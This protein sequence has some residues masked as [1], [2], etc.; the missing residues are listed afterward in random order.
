MKKVHPIEMLV[1][2]VF[3]DEVAGGGRAM[4]V[5][6]FD[7]HPIEAEGIRRSYVLSVDCAGHAQRDLK[8]GSHVQLVVVQSRGK[9][10]QQPL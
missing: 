1:T 7:R 3:R 8:N 4:G 9:V 5:S 2:A 6:S 10:G